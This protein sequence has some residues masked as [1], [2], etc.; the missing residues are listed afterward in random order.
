MMIREGK[1]KIAPERYKEQ[2]KVKS[3]LHYDIGIMFS[4]IK[5]NNKT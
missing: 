3:Y 4:E 5:R 2:K 1:R